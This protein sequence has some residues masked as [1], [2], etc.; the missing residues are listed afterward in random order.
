MTAKEREECISAIEARALQVRMMRAEKRDL[1]KNDCLYNLRKLGWRKLL[2]YIEERLYRLQVFAEKDLAEF[3]QRDL[4]AETIDMRNLVDF[5][6]ILAAEERKE[7]AR[8][9]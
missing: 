8:G 6:T 7:V 1:S 3:D 9:T 5:V 2:I 4:E